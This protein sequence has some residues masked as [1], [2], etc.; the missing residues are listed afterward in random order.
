MIIQ[1]E[2]PPYYGRRIY[3]YQELAEA[4]KLRPM[5]WAYF[6]LNAA[7][8]GRAA[9]VIQQLKKGKPNFFFPLSDWEFTSRNVDG[10]QRVYARF[11]GKSEENSD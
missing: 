11:I 6:A 3:P 9:N 5:E 4:C 8:S 10:E 7:H 1:F 2:E